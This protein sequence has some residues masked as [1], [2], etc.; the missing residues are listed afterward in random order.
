MD[1][2]EATNAAGETDQDAIDQVIADSAPADPGTEQHADGSAR[3]HGGRNVILVLL[4]IAAAVTGALGFSD[5]F[6]PLYESLVSK[7][8]HTFVQQ[9]STKNASVQPRV[10]APA[11]TAK[12]VP[13]VKSASA[14]KS[15]P[16]IAHQQPAVSSEDVRELLS[17]IRALQS[18][19]QQMQ[20]S[21]RA[22]Q[23][24]LQE[25]QQM[26]LQIRLRWIADPASRL[27]QLQLIWEEISLLPGLSDRER[28]KAASMHA[29]ARDRVQQIKQWQSTLNKWADVLSTSRQNMN[30]LPE[31]EHPWLAWVLQQFQLRQA[32]SFEARQRENL[33]DRLLDVSRQLT[34]E[35]WPEKGAWQSLQAELLLQIKAMQHDSDAAGVETGLPEDFDAIRTDIHTLRQTALQWNQRQSDTWRQEAEQ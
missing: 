4:F 5:Q 3:S 17:S 20:Q 27:P 21:Q 35:S 10:N 2:P 25:Q 19:L 23:N 29:L 14:T 24:G 13:A 7:F 26:N 31:S 32:P 12:P 16:V 34:L 28:E 9:H 1:K 18:Q 15:L 6:T 30:I 22:L 33:R 8:N 11:V